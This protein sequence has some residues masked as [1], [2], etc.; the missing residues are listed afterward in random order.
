MFYIMYTTYIYVC[1][2]IYNTIIYIVL[3][4]N[5]IPFDKFNLSLAFKTRQVTVWQMETIQYK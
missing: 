2:C 3:I 1:V 4:W 5:K